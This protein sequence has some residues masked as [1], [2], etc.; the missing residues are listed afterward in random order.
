M[1]QSTFF[2]INQ[3]KIKR[4]DKKKIKL[5]YEY[6][7]FAL[8]GFLLGQAEILS[9]LYP[10]VLV[11]WVISLVVSYYFFIS[12]VFTTGVGLFLSENYQNLNYVI[13]GLLGIILY[14]LFKNKFKKLDLPFWISISY[15]VVTLISHYFT[16]VLLYEYFITLG[17]VVVIY[18]LSGLSIRGIN[19][20]LTEQT[21]PS[22]L[23]YLT[24]FLISCGVL[25]GIANLD[26]IPV[27]VISILVFT[28]IM[29]AAYQSGF[30]YSIVVAVLYGLVLVCAG[31]IPMVI[32]IKYIIFAFSCGIFQKKKKLW[33][34]F[35][36]LL[37]FMIYSGLS[38]A[39]SD[40]QGT[41]L[42]TSAALI[43]F[44]LI[45]G[46]VWF[47]IYR[48]FDKGISISELEVNP[49]ISR[50][51]KK[52]LS[53]LA[54][55][56]NELSITFKDVIPEEVDKGRIGDFIFI[57]KN[58]ICSRCQRFNLC[59]KE[60]KGD[61]YS[62]LKQILKEG[63]Q[64]GTIDE[65]IL[66]KYLREKCPFVE[67]IL[68]GIK[69]SYEMYQ[70]NKF[71]RQRLNDE[72]E[73]V[74]EQLK[75]IGDIISQFSTDSGLT[76]KRSSSLAHIKEKAQSAEI[77]LHSID[78]DSNIKN[79][80]H[81]IT[82]EMEQ[83]S[84]HNPCLGQLL[85][86]I[87]S[88]FEYKFRLITRNCGNKLKDCPCQI[89][90]G[91]VGNHKLNISHVQRPAREGISGDSI[92]YRPLKDGKDLIV[93][94]D[95]MGIGEKAAQESRTAINLLES[96]IDAGFDQ[97][98]AIK[99][100]NSA[101]Y[102]RNQEESFTTLDIA[103]FDTFSGELTLNKIGAVAS[104]IKRGWDLIQIDSA[105][106]PVGI[107]NKIDISSR[108]VQL[109]N[110]DFVIMLTDGVLDVR[111][112]IK[113]KEDWIK[114]TLQNSSF[115]EPEDLVNYLMEIILSK[116]VEIEDDMTIVVFRIEEHF[117]K[118]RKF[119]ALSR[120]NISN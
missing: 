85:D 62:K 69:V 104:F 98:L 103:L 78:L 88:E 14:Q 30:I 94:S 61:T 76:F 95:G 68:P 56:F 107:L 4:N 10:L 65:I 114:Q 28:I 58:K 1:S 110:D 83:C 117:N 57:F 102:L 96:I 25:L 34:V 79:N 8:F 51:L 108:T 59:W 77:D 6:L 63:E 67:H 39:L 24:L 27:E 29:G 82:V 36:S 100:I 112:D 52:H 111:P 40:L 20:Y 73:I 75:G 35:G 99:T 86:I 72:Q 105:S 70:I 46:K 92:L 38:P 26:Y 21:K 3:Q 91:P 44:L 106:L 74:S 32:M 18:L 87:N 33:M 54:H 97:N 31:I 47:L 19:Q 50:G 16:G 13:G 43:L 15:L 2:A 60:E 48:G 55:V 22:S 45:P 116:N 53:E 120:I 118:R 113:E 89:I 9:G 7:I 66:K 37:G 11:Y 49:D 109:Q 17:E 115:D 23:A 42:E 71:W 84:G 81:T 119:E 41:V 12:V 90:Y 101:L 5:K 80:L 93:L 64:R